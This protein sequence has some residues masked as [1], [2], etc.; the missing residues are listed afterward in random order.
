MTLLHQDNWA[1]AGLL[2]TGGK[3]HC[4]I[5]ASRYS[6]LEDSLRCTNLLAVRAE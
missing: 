6:G 3:Q 5:Q 4:Q 2:Q 1:K